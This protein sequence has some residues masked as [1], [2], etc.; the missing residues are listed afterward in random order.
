M[1]EKLE[2]LEKLR[3]N[4]NYK[5]YKAFE[6]LKSE[7]KPGSEIPFDAWQRFYGSL[8]MI[9]NEQ[10]NTFSFTQEMYDAWEKE[11]EEIKKDLF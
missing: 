4:P 5:K 6:R 2:I 9:Y 1:K 10:N 7:C 3:E 8:K 11:F